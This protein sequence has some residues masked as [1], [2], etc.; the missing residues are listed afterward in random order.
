[1]EDVIRQINLLGWLVDLLQHAN[2]EWEAIPHRHIASPLKD[3]P[4]GVI[5]RTPQEALERLR[6]DLEALGV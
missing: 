3:Q 6:S 2:Y 4:P 5:G 1:M